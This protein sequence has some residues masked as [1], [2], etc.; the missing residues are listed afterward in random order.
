MNLKGLLPEPIIKP[1]K[2]IKYFIFG[3][4]YRGT[5]RFCPVCEKSSVKFAPLGS[6]PR[7]D[8][9]CMQC[10]TF[11]RHRLVWEFFKRKT[12]LFDGHKINMLHIAPEPFFEKRLKKAIGN[13]YLSADLYDKKAM[14]KMDITN[15]HFTDEYFDVIYCSHV[16]EHIIDDRKAMRELRRV[17]K[18][19]GWAVIMVPIN[20]ET[21]FED[22]SI[23]TPKER[24]KIFG[25]EDHVRSYGNDFID[26]LRE[27]GFIVNT[28]APFDICEKEDAIRFG[29]AKSVDEV[30]YCKKQL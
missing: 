19:S 11:E 29:I 26:R 10:G 7:E 8:V 4:P 22:F 25:Q 27:A 1:I 23:T 12:N 17:L 13:G 6:P 20:T 15:I 16:L 9:K 24:L 28:F 3:L 21:T 2:R 5:G 18:S 30:F 14:V